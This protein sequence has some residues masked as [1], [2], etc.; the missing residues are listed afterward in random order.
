MIEV[1]LIVLVVIIILVIYYLN[2]K[3]LNSN[4]GTNADV[5][6]D[7]KSAINKQQNVSLQVK[8]YENSGYGGKE[9]I[10]DVGRYDI[11]KVPLKVSS[12]KIPDNLEVQIFTG[13]GYTGNNKILTSDINSL[14][15]VYNDNIQSLIVYE[16][17]KK[18]S[19]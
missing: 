12:F 7:V 3:Q 15:F 2:D 18:R 6:L 17:D 1:Y 13:I 14:D 4:V 8:A 16:V 19:N 5:Y 9:F 10:L 11:D